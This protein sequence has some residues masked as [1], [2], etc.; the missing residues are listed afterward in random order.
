[1][2]A[3]GKGVALPAC[4]D[5]S[6]VLCKRA[7]RQPVEQNIGVLHHVNSNHDADSR[8]STNGEY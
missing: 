4:L 2:N 5:R 8:Y 1:M 7:A 6:F 3:M